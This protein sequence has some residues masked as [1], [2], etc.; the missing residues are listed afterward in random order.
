MFLLEGLDRKDDSIIYIFY[1]EPE[2]QL[3]KSIWILRDV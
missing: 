2:V 3:H 1:T